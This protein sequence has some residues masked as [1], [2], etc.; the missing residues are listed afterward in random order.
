[1]E[2]PLAVG[3]VL[4]VL[5]IPLIAGKVPPNGLYGFRTPQTL[6]SPTVWYP[7][8]RRSGIYFS[9][10]GCSIL[11]LYGAARAAGHAFEEAPWTMGL[12]IGVPTGAALIASF[13]YLRKL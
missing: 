12:L 7:A 2:A 11:A 9:L 6:S 3:G 1:M 13:A 8:N 10:A 4:I 5:S